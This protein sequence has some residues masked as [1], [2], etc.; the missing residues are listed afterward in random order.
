MQSVGTAPGA[1]HNT[2]MAMD[3]LLH[4]LEV[5]RKQPSPTTH[6]DAAINVGWLKLRKYYQITDLVPSYIMA[7]FLN[8]H[9]CNV[10]FEEH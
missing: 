7:V 3:Y 5:R 4:H 10:W 1:L 8:P 6:F 2:L 9:Y